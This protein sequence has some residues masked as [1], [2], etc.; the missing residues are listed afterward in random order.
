MS[1]V[2]P[3][4]TALTG[5]P[6]LRTDLGCP[7]Q[8]A[9]GDRSTIVEPSHLRRARRGG[10]PCAGADRRTGPLASPVLT[11]ISGDR[12]LCRRR[13]RFARRHPSDCERLL[14]GSDSDERC[15]GEC[16]HHRRLPVLGDGDV[17]SGD[18]PWQTEAAGVKFRGFDLDIENPLSVRHTEMPVLGPRCFGSGFPQHAHVHGRRAAL[19][20]GEG[21]QRWQHRPENGSST[22]SIWRRRT[23]TRT[24]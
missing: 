11:G 23:S 8:N 9:P 22:T 19:P 24:P 17:S 20:A 7:S 12:R 4:T 2:S 16:R 21:G 1:N 3:H 14:D 10:G 6:S 5:H 15:S 18:R 13:R